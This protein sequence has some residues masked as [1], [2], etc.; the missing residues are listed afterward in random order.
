MK[1]LSTSESNMNKLCKE[2]E[3]W[4][5]KNIK[6]KRTYKDF[7]YKIMIDDNAL[8]TQ[9]QFNE[10]EKVYIEFCN[11][12]GEMGQE[13][14]KLKNYDK[15]KNWV[16]S[17]Y[18]DF[19]REDSIHFI[20]DWKFYYNQYKEKCKLIVDDEKALANIAVILCYEKYP[21]KSKKFIWQITS[22]GILSN[23]KQ[24]KIKLP[25]RDDEGNLEYLGK[26]YKIVEVD[27]E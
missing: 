24:E 23:I 7:N 5:K 9:E 13:Q 10:I 18:P 14:F 20:M 4:Q 21:N 17:F 16:N 22:D 2:I 6:F 11:E 19:T 3:T 15:Y 12:I 8:Y 27:Y 1:K 25:Q 26:K